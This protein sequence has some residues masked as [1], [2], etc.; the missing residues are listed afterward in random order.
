MAAGN[1]NQIR[2]DADDGWR[3][4][5]I[6]CRKNTRSRAY[7]KSKALAAIPTGTIGGPVIE[8]HVVKILDKYGFEV[9]FPQICKLG[10]TSCVVISGETE[11]FVNGIPKHKAEVRTSNELV[12][13]LQ[14]SNKK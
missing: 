13:N 7:P 2:L 12:E 6:L 10:D 5:T 9:A 1:C 11:R 4:L 8:V 14:E 3:K